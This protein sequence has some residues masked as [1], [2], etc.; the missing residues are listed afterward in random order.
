MGVFSVTDL[1]PKQSQKVSANSM[2]SACRS[3]LQ[4]SDLD[5]DN[6]DA[7]WVTMLRSQ[8]HFEKRHGVIWRF[9][10]QVE[11]ID[12]QQ[13]EVGDADRKA[14][15]QILR[16]SFYNR[17][18]NLFWAGII[19]AL[20]AAVLTPLLVLLAGPFTASLVCIVWAAIHRQRTI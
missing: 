15:L 1:Y 7:A 20:A 4:A 13:K 10:H 11:T 14:L 6:D 3:A 18:Y 8:H 2:A 16:K 5:P 19:F 9:F 12:N 17:S